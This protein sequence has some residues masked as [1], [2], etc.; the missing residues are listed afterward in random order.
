[1]LIVELLGAD[2]H[3]SYAQAAALVDELMGQLREEAELLAAAPRACPHVRGV[4]GPRHRGRACFLTWGTVSRR[5]GGPSLGDV[6]RSH[7]C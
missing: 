3:G 5:A 1:M 2:S 7:I 6:T 4:Q